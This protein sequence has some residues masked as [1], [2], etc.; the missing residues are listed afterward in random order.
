MKDGPAFLHGPV[1]PLT[2]AEV[3]LE[4]FE[5]EFG[6]VGVI[7]SRFQECDDLNAAGDERP[8]DGGTDEATGTGDEDAI[9]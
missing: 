4:P 9:S 3:D 1:H 7:G 8:G 2:V 5:V 6:Q